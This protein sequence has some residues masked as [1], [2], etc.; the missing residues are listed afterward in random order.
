[1]AASHRKRSC[2]GVA[3]FALALISASCSGSSGPQV[4]LT[5]FSVSV[6]PASAAS[7][8]TTFAVS[9]V[10]SVIHEF[11]VVKTD[12][13]DADLPTS[14]DGSVDEEGEGIEPIDEIED[15]EVDGSGELTV[16]LDEG[17]YVLFCNVVDGGVAHYE[18]GMHTS[19]TVE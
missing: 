16:D 3:A 6:D 8:E 18:K 14:E 15:I 4:E 12:L 7:G 5:E 13:D 9:N 11:V 10:G 2:L 17:N 19:F 1:M